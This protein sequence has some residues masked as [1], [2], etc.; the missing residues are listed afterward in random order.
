[1]RLFNFI[2][3]ALVAFILPG[4]A[5]ADAYPSKP[6]K[7]IVPF[8]V[9][10]GSDIIARLMADELRAQLGGNFIVDNKPGASAIIGAEFVSKS[11]PDGYTLFVST[12][13]AHNSN[14]SLFKK[15]PYEPIKDFQ[16]I[17]NMVETAFILIVRN[18][19]PAKTVAELV[20]WLKAN[21]DRGSW[22]H[23]SSTSQVSG[24]TFVKRAGV[25][26]VRVPYKS[27]PQVMADLIGGQITFTFLDLAAAQQ[28]FKGGKVR[29][30]AMTTAKRS[31]IM[32]EVPTLAE[33]GYPGFDLYSWTGLLAPAGT[34]REI[35]Q[36]L[37]AAV[38]KTLAKKEFQE[39]MAGLGSEVKPQTPEEM[40]DYMVLQLKS[41]TEKIR[42]AGI[43]PE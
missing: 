10:S 14:P 3:S 36:T 37:N 22:G 13:T 5:I 20:A 11:A 29:G 24:A 7:I 1:M 30:I 21:P 27:S 18:D 16:P 41:W 33:S 6:V 32:P 17:T 4:A 28:Y 40:R 19:F 8:A 35:I 38:R 23:G 39:R 31:A 43:Q 9:A 42:D 34:P 25:P 2:C 26:A 12:N 15:L